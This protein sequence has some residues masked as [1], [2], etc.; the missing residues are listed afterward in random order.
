L[1]AVFL[2]PLVGWDRFRRIVDPPRVAVWLLWGLLFR[3]MF[4]SGVVKL[5]SGDSTWRTLSALAFHYET[6]PLPTPVAWY[7]YHL[8][9]WFHHG[10]TA[11]VLAIELGVPWLIFAPRR[12]RAVGGALLIGLQTLIALTGNY[13]FFNLLSIGLCLFLFDDAALGRLVRGR[14]PDV[15]VDAAPVRSGRWPAWVLIAVAVLTVPLSVEALTREW[16][17]RLWGSAVL[18]PLAD[19]IEPFRSVNGYG[20]FAVMTTSRPEIVVEGSNDGVTWLPYEFTD[21]PGD[22][23]RRP[24]WVAPYQPRLDWQMWFA[25]LGRYEDSPWFEQ[26]CRRL[27]EGSPDVL[28]LLARDPFLGTPPRFVRGVLYQ[29]R[30]ADTSTHRAQGVWWVRQRLGLYSPVWTVNQEPR[31]FEAR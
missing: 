30:F 20:L 7:A 18:A 3:L 27:L 2:A 31:S 24:S 19:F 25:A 29:Y 17:A 14:W 13:A 21:K 5:A 9:Q 28:R 15:R 8:P 16:G 11:L 22:Q 1:L 6:Q 26:F 10:S 4:G 12:L 23:R